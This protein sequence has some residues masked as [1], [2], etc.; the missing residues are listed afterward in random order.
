MIRKLLAAALVAGVLSLAPTLAAAH[1]PEW[2]VAYRCDSWFGTLTLSGIDSGSHQVIV[3]RDSKVISVGEAHGS[4]TQV[5]RTIS[6]RYP[7]SQT[8]TAYVF[9]K[10]GGSYKYNPRLLSTFKPSGG[11]IGLVAV[12]SVKVSGKWSCNYY[13]GVRRR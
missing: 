3:T 13:G 4:G 11:G 6:G 7:V 1:T 2:N 8:Y 12:A 9:D 10:V 5:L